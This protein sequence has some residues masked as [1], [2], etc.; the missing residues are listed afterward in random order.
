[1]ALRQSFRATLAVLLLASRSFALTCENDG[2]VNG[3]ICACPVGFG[4]DTCSSLGCGGNIFQGLDRNQTTTTDGSFANLTLSGCSCE[5]GWTGTGCNVCQTASACQAAY[6]SVTSSAATSTVSGLVGVTNDTLVC[7]TSPEVYASSQMSC[8]VDVAMLS[9]IYP[10]SSSLNIMRT[11][12]PSLSPIPNVTSFGTSGTV[13]AQLFYNGVEQFY[14]TA[15]SCTESGTNSS[16]W[17]CSNLACTCRVNTTFCG[18]VTVSDLTTTIDSLTGTLDIDCE[19][20]STSCSFVQSTLV[21]LFGS[22]GLTLTGCTFGECVRQSV[23]DT[24]NTTTTEN[25][26]GSSP[27]DG[28]VIAGLAVVGGLIIIALA[29]ILFGFIRQ[30]AARRVPGGE[31]PREAVGVQWSDVSYVLPKSRS[32]F[33]RS[34]AGVDDKV[35]LDNVSGC[36]FPGQTLAILGPSGAGKTTLVEI[37]AGKSKSGIISGNITFSQPQARRPRIAFVS[38]LDVLPPTLTVFETLMFAARLRLP[39]NLPDAEKRARVERLMETLGIDHVRDSRIGWG[40]DV[41]GSRTRGISGGE[42]RRVSIGLEL[43]ASPDVLILD[44]PTS[45]LDSVSAARITDVLHAISRDP[46]HPTA[47][48]CSI[49]QPNSRLYQTFDSVMLLAHGRAL[50]SGQGQLA[51]LDYFNGTGVVPPCPAGYNVADYLLEIA[52]DPPA[53]LFQMDPALAANNSVTLQNSKTTSE[54]EMASLDRDVEKYPS[55]PPPPT[56]WRTHL[57]PSSYPA[58]FL[59]Q[60]EVLAGREWKN[61]KRDKTLIVLHISVA[62]VLG[63][64]C[65]GLYFHTGDSIA[66]FQSRIGCLFFLG[67]LVAFS[68]L[69]ALYN[70]VEMRPLFLRER[71]NDYYSP[72]AWLLSRF[73]F[74]V[75]PLRLVPS[76]IVSTITYWMTGLAPEAQHFFKFLL[77]IVLYTL[78]ITLFNFLLGATFHNGGVAI[79]MSALTVLY[80]MTFAGFF[81]HLTSISPVLRWLQWIC[82]LKYMLEALSVNEVGSGL[83]ISDELEGVPVNVSASLIM[84][85]LFGFG[86]NNYYRDVLVL[87]AFIAGFAVM[88]VVMVWIRVRE[89]L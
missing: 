52:S 11:L 21:S 54:K 13:Y 58:T 47:V 19:I 81:V 77:I 23:I 29:L 40:G 74:D 75:V 14:C 78:A 2:F 34:R 12:D 57:A 4:G 28:G 84:G 59:T 33:S 61:L 17:S 44:E 69:S 51:P 53:V 79:L 31:L 76:I 65:G 41:T 18:A 67:A 3:S 9:A 80:Q 42:M 46:D 63:V 66:G 15:D 1:M 37:L 86:E 30:R 8:D 38:Q 45:G 73:L 62:A 39:E 10:G 89:R 55:T 7:S 50:Y 5:S 27:L 64:I 60:L 16:S 6:S 70:V 56:G 72:T 48:I 32:W 20:G 68:C 24:T 71:S 25:T 43:V 22:S 26:G 82:P 35:I 88:V 49:H 36:V 85:I 83:M 87:F